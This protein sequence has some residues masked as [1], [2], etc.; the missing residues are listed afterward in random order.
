MRVRIRRG[1]RFRRDVFGGVAYVPDRDDF[2]AADSNVSRAIDSTTEDWRELESSEEATFRSL[3]SIGICETDPAT[4]QIA[5]SGPSFLGR[6]I[7]LPTVTEPLVLN[8]F[9]TSHCPLMCRYCHADDLMQSYRNSESEADLE[10]VV[11]TASMIPA[12]VAVITGGDPLSAPE[13]ASS[14]ISRLSKQKAIV[15]DTSGVGEIER[16]LPV[17]IDSH[18]HVRISLDA[19]SDSNAK[20]RPVNPSY[21]KDKDASRTGA[22][23]T[24]KTCIQHNIPV[25]VQTVISSYN[26]RFD[27]LRNLRDMIARW[28]VRHWVLH[29]AIR[30]GLARKIEDQADKQ[31]RRRGILPSVDAPA[32]VRK[33]LADTES[34]AIE[35]DIRCT[36]TDQTPNSVLLVGST[37]DLFTEGLAHHGKVPLYR[38]GQGRPDLV[39]SLWHHVDRFGHARRYFNWNPWTGNGKNLEDQCFPI[40]INLSPDSENQ[41]AVETEAKFPVRDKRLLHE[42]LEIEGFSIGS[43]EHQRDEYFDREDKAFSNLDFVI[44][45]REQNDECEVGLKGPRFYTADG[46]YSRIELEFPA[47]SH[48]DSVAAFRRRELERYWFF[49]KR[50]TTYRRSRDQ[51][52]VCVDELPVLGQYLEIEGKL[53]IIRSL[54]DLLSKAIGDPEVRHYGDLFKDYMKQQ[55]KVPSE[56]AGAEFKTED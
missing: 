12:M 6:F 53:E 54:R 50:R 23:A 35:M 42:L 2:F 21:S 49:E 15:V 29:V 56:I 9:C 26:E 44:R 39:R 3:A 47:K 13:R 41:S 19:A 18:A 4:D 36:D 1:V 31:K 14:L 38:A 27:E 22:A 30:G 33:L 20:V 45:V 32:L 37:G 16:L 55:G 7:E 5:Y 46:E 24:I 34:N 51:T 48:A 25:T 17:L 11:S 28:G 40:P 10:N 52:I 8:C 43:V